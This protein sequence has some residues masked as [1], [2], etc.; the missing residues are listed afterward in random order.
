MFN[1]LLNKKLKMA[2]DELLV[3]RERQNSIESEMLTMTVNVD[4]IITGI[5]KNFANLVGYQQEALIGASLGMLSPSYVKELSCYKRFMNAI[6]AGVAVSD[7]YRYITAEEKMVWIHAAWCPTK[8]ASGMVTS[9]SCYGLDATKAIDAAR[10]DSELIEALLRSTAVIEF[11]LSGKI[12]TANSAFLNAVGYS[13]KQLEG[14]HH[15]IFCEPAYTSSSEYHEFWN[16]LNSGNFVASRFKRIDSSGHEVWLEA[17][18]NPVHDTRGKLYKVVKFATVV[19]DQVRR[20]HEISSAANTAHDISQQ[21]DVSANRGADVVQKTVGTM[22]KIVDQ[23][24]SAS[25][26]IEALGK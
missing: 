16:T 5:N 9:M 6:S 10:E 18:Y 3:W 2:Q 22:N 14:K 19:T 8:N 17:T 25:E 15:S 7:D 12:L 20:E 24:S 23:I 13:L 21:T 4:M 11:D 1:K 26:G